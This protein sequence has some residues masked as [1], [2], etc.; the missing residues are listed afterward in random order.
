MTPWYSKGQQHRQYKFYFQYNFVVITIVIIIMYDYGYYYSYYSLLLLRYYLVISYHHVLWLLF[1]SCFSYLFLMVHPR[2]TPRASHAC[3]PSGSVVRCLSR[4]PLGWEPGAAG[5][6][7]FLFIFS[8]KLGKT[9]G[10]SMDPMVIQWDSMESNGDSIWMQTLHVG[11]V[12]LQNP[13]LCRL[14]TGS[15]LRKVPDL[16]WWRPRASWKLR[17]IAIW[18]WDRHVDRPRGSRCSTLWRARLRSPKS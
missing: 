3:W 11:A 9:H 7:F 2:T 6:A 13:E 1:F 17:K 5:G 12:T 15:R 8:G 18:R 14:F 10:D 16:D 4:A